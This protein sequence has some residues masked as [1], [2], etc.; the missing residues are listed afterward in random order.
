MA[1]LAQ[2]PAIPTFRSSTEIVLVPV[3]VKDGNRRVTGL[4]PSDFQLFDNGVVQEI[5]SATAEP[6]PVDITLVL[7]TSGSLVGARLDTIKAGVQQIAQALSADDR[8]RLMTFSTV[9]TEAFGIRS[10][11]T[12]LPVERIEGGGA[13]AF[14]DALA[15]ALISVPRNDRP[16]LVLGISDGLDTLSFLD[17]G[18]VVSLAGLSGVSLY[19]ALVGRAA[20]PV[21]LTWL[22]ALEG[23]REATGRTGGLLFEN[24]PG[25]ALPVLF[26]QTL[27]D[28]RAS[29]LLSY[30]PRGVRREGWHQIVVRTK[31]GRHAV[32][33]RG[34]YQQ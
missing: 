24:P 22:R 33:A 31:D 34:G 21:P 7:D 9:V 23:L 18:Q 32:R 11:G 16:Q 13:T 1:P 27:A 15:A 19:V 12:L 17:V 25:A 2:T 8:V 26:G 20:G 10:G 6:Q 14:Y 30:S 4:T 29:Y 5:S 3:W 28:F